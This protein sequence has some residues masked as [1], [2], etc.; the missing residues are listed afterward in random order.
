MSI[1]LEHQK[2]SQHRPEH[3]TLQS[4]NL[5]HNH[6]FARQPQ[7]TSATDYAMAYCI[8]SK[9]YSRVNKS[10]V[11]GA[12]AVACK[13][14][15]TTADAAH[16]TTAASWFLEAFV[17]A[18]DTFAISVQPDNSR[19]G[20]LLV[21]TKEQIRKPNVP[22]HNPKSFNPAAGSEAHN[23]INLHLKPCI[24]NPTATA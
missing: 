18:P 11:Q 19:S 1:G 5:D 22:S 7:M 4:R 9:P 8:R 12:T 10:R 16:C 14:L 3:S 20:L 24:L 21:N 13:S 6:T 15:H 23:R 2:P 17:L